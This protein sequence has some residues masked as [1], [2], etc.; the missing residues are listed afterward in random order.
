LNVTPDTPS[1]IAA[2]KCR[3]RHC[4]T[5]WRRGWRCASWNCTRTRLRSCTARTQTDRAAIRS[6]DS[7]FWAIRFGPV[8]R[9]NRTGKLFV[10]FF[11]AVSEKAAKAM[12]TRLRR[13]KL[14]HRND[15]PLAEIAQW[16]RPVLQ[17]WVQYYG[18]F[19]RSALRGA[20]RTLDS[21]I[22]RWAQR[23]YKRLRGHTKQA[24]DWLRRLQARQ[25]TCLPTGSRM[26]RLDDRSR[27]NREVHVRFWEG[28]GVKLLCATRLSAAYANGTEARASLKIY[29]RFYNERPP[30][31]RISI[32]R[33]RTRCITQT[34]SHR[35]RRPR[36]GHD[37]QLSHNPDFRGCPGSGYLKKSALGAFTAVGFFSPN[38]NP[39]ASAAER[40]RLRLVKT[41]DEERR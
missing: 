28:V 33:R 14:H 2:T 39:G 34:W 17:G 24:W 16:T 4:A 38:K 1:V 35:C 5:H 18:R 8:G 27:M 6:S 32:T 19:H 26:L 15:L 23:K 22:V 25:P 7:T 11:P 36:D 21:F 9:L 3:R 12:R 41:I 37:Q 13:W 10:S 20:L 29:F 30:S 31:L 40:G